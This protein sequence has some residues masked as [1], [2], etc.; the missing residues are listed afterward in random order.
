MNRIKREITKEQFV[1]VMENHD[2][3]DIFTTQEVMGYG[4]YCDRYF[5][6]KETGKYYVEYSVGDSCD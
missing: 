6:D 5:Q 4:V 3:S 2:T 1:N